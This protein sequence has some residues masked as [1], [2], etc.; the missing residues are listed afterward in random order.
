MKGKAGGKGKEKLHEREGKRIGK[1]KEEE[2]EEGRK[3]EGRESKG[4]GEG[5]PL[6]LRLFLV[7]G[8]GISLLS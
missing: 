6:C 8:I 2:E 5:R 4:E 7:K 3:R 1:W